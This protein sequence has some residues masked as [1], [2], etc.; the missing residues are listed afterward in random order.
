MWILT[1][2]L[3]LAGGDPMPLT[4]DTPGQEQCRAA[5]NDALRINEAGLHVISATCERVKEA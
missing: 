4:F 1:V 2:V 3:M 5:A